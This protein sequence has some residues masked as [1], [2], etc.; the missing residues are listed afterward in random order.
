MLRVKSH[1]SSLLTSA[2]LEVL[3]ISSMEGE[4][5]VGITGPCLDDMKIQPHRPLTNT[6]A[7]PISNTGC[8]RAGVLNKRDARDHAYPLICREIKSS[9]KRIVNL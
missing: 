6:A 2:H 9:S 5:V 4:K 3:K 7:I 8:I 1:N